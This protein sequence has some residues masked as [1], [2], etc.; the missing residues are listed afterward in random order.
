MKLEDINIHEVGTTIRLVGAIYTDGKG[1]FLA[2]PLPGEDYEPGQPTEAL[3]MDLA[4][5]QTFVHQ[6]DLVEIPA[7]VAQPDGKTARI[8]VR[9]TARQIS[10]NVSWAVYRRDFIRCRYCGCN[11]VPLT[12]DHLVLWEDG[13]PSTEA[14][15]VAACKKCNNTRGNTPYA[16]WLRSRYYQRVSQNLPPMVQ[17]ANEKLAHT[18]AAIPRHPLKG[19]RKR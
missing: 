14:N 15:L 5:W 12:V 3:T 19:K 7:L 10:Q 1:G 17:E 6:T 9:K 18:L 8:L 2:L 13:G 11:D 4:D 16:E